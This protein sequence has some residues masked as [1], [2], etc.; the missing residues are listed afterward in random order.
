[1]ALCQCECGEDAGQSTFRPGHDQRLR[2]ELEGRVGGLLT[3]RALVRAM[4]SYSR[5]ITSTEALAQEIRRAFWRDR[6]GPPGTRTL[7]G[8]DTRGNS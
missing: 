7:I 2:A 5:G 8:E 6:G 3:M 1:M 4:E